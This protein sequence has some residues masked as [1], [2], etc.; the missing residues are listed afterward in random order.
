MAFPSYG[1][2]WLR[3]NLGVEFECFSSPL[4]CWCDKYFSVAMDTDQ[5]FGSLGNFFL[6]DI[7]GIKRDHFAGGS[8]EVN[9]PFV[10]S[11]MTRTVHHI[12]YLLSNCDPWIPLSFTIILPAWIGCE[13]VETLRHCEF[14]QPKREYMLVLKRYKHNYMPG[15]QHRASYTEQASN[16][17]TL[18]F[19]LQNKSA[20]KKWPITKSLTDDLKSLLEI[21]SFKSSTQNF[22]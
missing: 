22:I 13:A 21:E 19:F 9:P 15:M 1:F 8:F 20:S 4:N 12:L 6:F 5:H 11:I 10:D 2:Q 16:V 3:D 18:I 17:D 7:N 14:L